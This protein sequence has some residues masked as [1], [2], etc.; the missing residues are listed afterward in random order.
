MLVI[1]GAVLISNAA[2]AAISPFDGK[3]NPVNG[4]GY[5]IKISGN[6]QEHLLSKITIENNDIVIKNVILASHNN[7]EPFALDNKGPFF[8][9]WPDQA[10]DLVAG[11][12]PGRGVIKVQKV[13]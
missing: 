2:A 7:A 11:K 3:F 13:R 10:E 9:A 4:A 6:G 1:L 12:A 8:I 5:S